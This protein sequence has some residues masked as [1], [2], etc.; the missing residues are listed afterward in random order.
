[1]ESQ[2]FRRVEDRRKQ[3]KNDLNFQLDDWKSVT[4]NPDHP[5]GIER[6]F[7]IMFLRKKGPQEVEK[8]VYIG[9]YVAASDVPLLKKI[10]ITHILSVAEELPPKYPQVSLHW[11][12]Y[13]R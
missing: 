1:M 5:E 10:G 9:S 2:R 12:F 13:W 6:K 4:H 3:V 7:T 11:R 8:G